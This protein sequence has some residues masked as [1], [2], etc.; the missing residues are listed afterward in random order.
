MV[1]SMRRDWPDP[2][3]GLL[4]AGIVPALV[5]GLATAAFAH[6]LFHMTEA[7]SAVQ[8]LWAAPLLAGATSA[9]LWRPSRRRIESEMAALRGTFQAIVQ[10]VEQHGT[11]PTVRAR[12]ALDEREPADDT[13][14]HER[15]KSAAVR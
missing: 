8:M 5:G 2:M 1:V 10:L 13:A 14:D 12:V 11:A 9:L 7:M 3:L 4:A 6:D 15:Q